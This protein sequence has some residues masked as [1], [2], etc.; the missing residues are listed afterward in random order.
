MCG[1]DQPTKEGWVRVAFVSSKV[2]ILS[3]RWVE[4][5]KE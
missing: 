2:D 3:S 1:T 5:K 4:K